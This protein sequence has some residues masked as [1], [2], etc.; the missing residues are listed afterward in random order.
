M[1]R[2]IRI[3]IYAFAALALPLC[4]SAQEVTIEQLV[5]LALEQSPE[6]RA[7]RTEV[8]VAT[9][10]VT[11]AALRPNPMAN[12][13]H[14]QM[15]GGMMTTTVGVEWPLDLFRRPARVGVATRAVDI[16]ALSV[17]ERE[18]LLASAV[19]EQAGRLLAARRTLEVTNE[20]LAAARRTRDLLDRRVTEGGSPKIDANLAAVETLRIEAEAALAA[21]ELEAATIELKAVV[22][23]APDAPLVLRE[24]LESLAAAPAIPR[25]TPAAAMEARPDLREA[26]AR[27]GLADARAEDA[28]RQARTDVALVAG[29]GRAQFGFPQFG[30]DERG[31]RVPIRDIFHSVTVGAKVTL[32]L[33]NRNQGALAAA[34]AEREGAEALFTARQRA[35]RAEIDAAVAREREARRAVE[36]YATTVRDLARQNVDVMLEGYDLGRFPLSDVL[37]EQRRYLDVEA[38]YTTVLARAYEARA[39]MARAFGEMP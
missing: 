28:R 31:R 23:L 21:G 16:T 11:Q 14:E 10:Q 35:A 20:V 27:I 37:T 1:T 15:P 19:R 8:P 38:G 3:A 36:L 7:V 33:R 26:I 6:L 29:Y 18:R 39:A 34:Q 17:R 22:G 24:S 30:L 13:G 25:L 9:G 4:A 2:M 32:P 5:A 12:L